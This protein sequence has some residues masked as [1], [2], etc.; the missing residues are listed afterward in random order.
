M[1]RRTQIE[2]LEG[3]LNRIA[4]T[5]D[6]KVTFALT[7]LASGESISRHAGD[8]M[9]TASLIKVPILVALMCVLFP[10]RRSARFARAT[11][12]DAD[13]RFGYPKRR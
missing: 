10:R 11:R 5:H 6:G 8:V 2:H 13:P 12:G 7:D 9:P 3:E 4:D 1:E